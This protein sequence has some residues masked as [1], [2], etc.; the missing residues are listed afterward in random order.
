MVK[1][2]LPKI[3]FADQEQTAYFHLVFLKSVMFRPVK[4]FKFVK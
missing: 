4:N 3:H 2:D 1:N